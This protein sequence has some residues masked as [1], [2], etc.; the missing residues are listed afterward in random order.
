ME[1]K[2]Y[3]IRNGSMLAGVCTGIAAYFN[4]DV[5]IVRLGAVILACMGGVGIIPY[6]VAAIILPEGQ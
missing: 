3:R 6:I 2:L 5:N 4:V 1:K